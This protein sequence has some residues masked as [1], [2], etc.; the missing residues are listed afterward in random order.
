MAVLQLQYSNEYGNWNLFKNRSKWASAEMFLG[1]K[2]VVASKV[3]VKQLL[4]EY[5]QSI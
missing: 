3:F 2:E 4:V 5:W 1:H